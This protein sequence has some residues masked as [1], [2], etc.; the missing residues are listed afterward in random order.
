[1]EH[2]KCN[3]RDYPGAMVIANR[4][5]TTITN[6][7][8]VV[9]ENRTDVG[10]VNSSIAFHVPQLQGKTLSSLRLQGNNYMQNVIIAL[11]GGWTERGRE[12]ER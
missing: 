12:K 4:L 10:V 1:M 7:G 2:Q 6:Q 5:V 3:E 9:M 8:V 11:L